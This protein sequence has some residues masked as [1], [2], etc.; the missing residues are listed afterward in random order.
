MNIIF[1]VLHFRQSHFWYKLRTNNSILH[2]DCQIY[3]RATDH[4]VEL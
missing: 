3:C 1:R 2:D 4:N